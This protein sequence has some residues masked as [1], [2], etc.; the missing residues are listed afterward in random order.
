MGGMGEGL[1][2]RV[3]KQGRRCLSNNG[4]NQDRCQ[5][6]TRITPQEECRGFCGG[7]GQALNG[8]AGRNSE[9]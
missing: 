7:Q 5:D 8:P 4:P 9:V 2:W 3:H 6:Q 1:R